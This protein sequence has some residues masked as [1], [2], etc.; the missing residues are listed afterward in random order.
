MAPQ[1]AEWDK[2][3][4]G[5]GWGGYEEELEEGNAKGILHVRPQE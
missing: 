4:I 2:N 5:S 3:R 1:E